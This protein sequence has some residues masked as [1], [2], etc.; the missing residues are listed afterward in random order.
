MRRI[1]EHTPPQHHLALNPSNEELR[2]IRT[3]K[4]VNLQ[5]E[6]VIASLKKQFEPAVLEAHNQ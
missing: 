6:T 4:T 2:L 1:P 5:D 3:L